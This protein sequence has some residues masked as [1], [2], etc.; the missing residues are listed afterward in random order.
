MVANISCCVY[1]NTSS[2]GG[3]HLQKKIRQQASCLIYS[4]DLLKPQEVTGL[5]GF[6]GFHRGLG[7]VTENVKFWNIITS[8]S[9]GT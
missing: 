5:E 8:Y 1:V 3:T 4:R 7:Y 2:K 6:L 9:F